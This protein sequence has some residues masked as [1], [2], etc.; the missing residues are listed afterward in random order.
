MINDPNRALFTYQSPMLPQ[1]LGPVEVRVLGALIEKALSTPEHYPLSLNALTNACNQSSNRNPVLALDEG[2]VLGAVDI[3]RRLGLV[4]SFQGIGS[5]VPKF[6][7]LLEEECELSREEV[8]VLCVLALRGPQTSSEVRSRAARLMSTDHP[9]GIDAAVE[10][11]MA[12]TPSPAV[13][14]LARQPG[15]KEARYAHLLAGDVTYEEV[16]ALPA[17]VVATDRISALEEL[18]RDLQGE[19][20]NLRAQLADFRRQFE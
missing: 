3:L 1:N 11:L 19:V 18:T 8:A 2:S 14:R 13:T 9:D 20:A 4:R 15:Q 6:Q 7:H 12:R 5:R 10:A 17:Q 16:D